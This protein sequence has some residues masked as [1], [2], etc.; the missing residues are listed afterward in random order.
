MAYLRVSQVA[1]NL[2]DEIQSA[3]TALAAT[4][5]ISGTVLDLRFAD[6][7]DLTAA[8]A[9]ADLFAAKNLP[10]A[11]LV[12]GETRGAA[13]DLATDL[14]GCARWTDFGQRGGGIE[15][16]HC[17]GGE[18]R[19]REK[20]S[21]KSL[22]GAGDRAKPIPCRHERNLLPFIDHTSEADLVREKI[23]DGEE[24][25]DSTPPRADRA[26]KTVHP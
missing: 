11:I 16:G 5:K 25:E 6:G 7:D 4:N 8:K 19:G 14:R 22:R 15:T 10:L 9:T 23:K 13:A 21:G 1:D 26:A 18:N 2:A 24:D 3:Q 12:N 20:V 17:R